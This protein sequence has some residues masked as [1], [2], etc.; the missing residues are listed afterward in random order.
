MSVG[1]VVHHKQTSV[2][3]LKPDHVHLP[4][5]L[6]P[7]RILMPEEEVSAGPKGDRGYGAPGSQFPFIISVLTDV[8]TAIFVPA[9]RKQARCT[10][11]PSPGTCQN[12]CYPTA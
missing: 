4:G 7:P 3:Q 9:M 5:R 12:P 8:V 10:K 2:G 1:R 6:P 11:R